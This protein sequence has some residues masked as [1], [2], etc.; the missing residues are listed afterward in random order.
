MEHDER[1]P[2]FCFSTSPMPLLG[3]EG[4]VE[5]NTMF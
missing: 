5:I 4:S 2:F 1:V 3:R